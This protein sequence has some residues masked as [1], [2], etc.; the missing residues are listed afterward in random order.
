MKTLAFGN[1]VGIDDVEKA[2]FSFAGPPATIGPLTLDLVESRR[3]DIGAGPRLGNLLRRFSG[4]YLSVQL[5][6]M[7]DLNVDS[8]LAE[9][10]ALLVRSGLGIAIATHA[11]SIKVGGKVP[12]AGLREAFLAE[13]DRRSQ[14]LLFIPNI[15]NTSRFDFEDRQTFSNM[16]L[17]YLPSLNATQHNFDRVGLEAIIEFCR[18]S[19]LN[20]RDH[21]FKL[22]WAQGDKR[23]SYFSI[24]YHKQI[25]WLRTEFWPFKRYFKAL[26]DLYGGA[27]PLS[28]LEIVTNDDG[29]GIAARHALDGEIYWQYGDKES[30]Y[31]NMALKAGGSVKPR[32]RDAT[33]RGDPGQ[34]FSVMAGSLRTL[35]GI[36][37]VRSGKL[38]SVYDGTIGNPLLTTFG[39]MPTSYATHLRYMPGTFVQ[40]VIPILHS[41]LTGATHR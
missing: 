35:K 30:E 37:A 29:N 9:N 21:S 12:P 1:H 5:P 31:F 7:V 2:V 40:S 39:P 19:I 16:L 34:G 41:G 20:V 22:P 13:T 26:G 8:Y 6:P 11:G 10:W 38:L 24:R 27:E 28:F 17:A 14:N 32:A 36:G 33:A 25:R 18:E 4:D 23:V 3:I 15:H